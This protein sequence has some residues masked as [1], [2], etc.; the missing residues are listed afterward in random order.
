MFAIYYSGEPET[1][2]SP[3]A[4]HLYISRRDHKPNYKS[5]GSNGEYDFFLLLST[6][7]F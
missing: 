1:V 3:K 2:T 7:V 6:A 5:I 4:W